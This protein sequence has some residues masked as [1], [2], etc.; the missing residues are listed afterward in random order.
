MT[1]SRHV[2][3]ELPQFVRDAEG[4]GLSEQAREAI[5]NAVSADP[6]NGDEVRGSGGVRKVRFAGRG[7]GKSGGYRVMTAYFGQDIPVYLLAILSKGERANFS[8]V[9]IEGFRKLTNEIFHYW[10]RRRGR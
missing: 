7:K 3:A 1:I 9:E 8:A 5:I 4:L 10:R 6:L 2:V